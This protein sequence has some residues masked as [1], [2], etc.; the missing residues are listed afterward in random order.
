MCGDG[1]GDPRDDARTPDGDL[2]EDVA[3]LA[4]SWKVANESR[5]CWDGCDDCDRCRR[6]REVK[7]SC[8][9][10]AQK[11]GPFEGCHAVLDPEAYLE[12]CVYDLCVNDGD[13]VALCRVLQAYADDCREEG[14]AVAEWRTLA[15][16]PLSCPKN[17]NY[18][19]CGTSCP[20]TCN[21]AALPAD[22]ATAPCLE[23]CQCHDG[24]V[25]DADECVPRDQCG[26]VSRGLLHGPRE[27]FWSDD[28][29]TRSCSCEAGCLW[30]GCGPGEQCRV[31]DGI[32]GCHPKSQG[33]CRVVGTTHY[34]TFDGRRFIFQGTCLYQ[35]AGLCQESQGLV[36]FQVLVQNGR[37]NAHL[38]ASVA[39]VTI[40]VYG[41]TITIS[42]KHPGKVTL[43]DRLVNLPYRPSDGK[44]SIYRG[45]QEAVVETDFGLTVTYDWW[46]HLTVTVPGTYASSLC[47]LCGNFNGAV[48]DEMTTKSG[49]ATTNPDALG[50]SWKVDDVPGCVELSKVE[51]P[52]T[53]A[54][55]RRQERFKKSCG[56][57]LQKDGPFGACHG[58]VDAVKYFQSCLH[59]SCLFPDQEGVI[60]SV[61]AAYASACQAADVTIGRWRTDDFCRLSCPTNSHYEICSESC[62]RTCSSLS[63]PT[64]C[65]SRRCREGCACAD[66]FVLSGDECVPA[67][68]CGCHHRDFYYKLEETFSPAATG[69]CRCQAG[70]VVACVATSPP[71]EGG[72]DVGPRPPEEAGTCVA[73]GDRTYVSFDGMVFNISGTCSYVL[74]ETC[75]DYRGDGGAV[76]AFVVKIKKESRRK[77]K[78]SGVQELSVQVHGLMLTFKRSKRGEVTV[79]SVSH[80]LPVNLK[81]SRVL[82]HQHGM[83]VLLQTDFGLVV[84]YDLLHRVRVTAP[85][86][87]RGHLCGLCGNYNGRGDDDDFRLPVGQRVLDPVVFGSTRMVPDGSCGEECPP[88][89]CPEC[90]EEEKKLAVFRRRN[91]CGVLT[92]PKGPFAACREVIDPTPYL[93]AC[94]QELCLTKGESWVLCRSVQSYA[95]ACQDAGVAIEPWRKPSFCPINCPAKSS[96]SLCTNHCAHS[97][98]G[99][100]DASRCPKT[101]IEGCHCKEGLVFNG[102]GCVPEAQCGC[103]VDGVYY[104]PHQSVLKD[105]CRQRCTCVP[106]QGLT[107]HSHSCTGD[108]TCEIQDGVLSC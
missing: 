30:S 60:C 4:K 52:L 65:S 24:F 74:A 56:V 73:T 100:R 101:C 13:R 17:S 105:N 29:C 72:E 90:E 93:Q 25:L 14:V 47:G 71:G 87:Y 57:I 15:N 108:E 67:S 59:D 32:Q 45:G 99:R 89:E 5:S 34:E 31:V 103:F 54:A 61:I 79:D 66:G 75:G 40:K 94:L 86:S 83:G 27:T 92:V 1:N 8:G 28:A 38:L 53:A 11:P 84:T 77:K 69:R 39:L 68:R 102:H 76:E 23:T 82:V 36:G 43:D 18:M 55:R 49:R 107:C 35:L 58:R 3:K 46:S 97:C 80:H 9:L 81:S 48:G 91:Y 12:N 37:H 51:C 6:D 41:K 70:G 2:T 44:I 19:S 63:N 7:T 26:C 104:E 106:S 85:R 98:A 64:P 42:Q 22:C 88:G 50:R 20:T 62:S 96:Y 21:D 16:C 78:V 95:T 33:T 10:V